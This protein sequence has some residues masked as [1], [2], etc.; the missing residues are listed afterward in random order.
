[1]G[2]NLTSLNSKATT[3]SADIL[4]TKSRVTATENNIT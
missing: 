4:A 2:I 3:N 1:M